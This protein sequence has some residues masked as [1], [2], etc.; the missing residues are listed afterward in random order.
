MD[1][2]LNH[3]DQ[4]RHSDLD[5]QFAEKLENFILNEDISK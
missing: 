2:N 5:T 1:N 3:N 4:K